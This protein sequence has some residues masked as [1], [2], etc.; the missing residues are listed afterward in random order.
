MV[1]KV[2]TETPLEGH[3]LSREEILKSK[4]IGI[5]V[6]FVPEWGGSVTVKGLSGRQRDQFEISLLEG[7]GKN[8]QVNLRNLRAKL[9]AMTI[10]NDKGNP[11][12]DDTDAQALG[13]KSASALQKVYVV[14]TR[15]SGLGEDDVEELT[16]ELGKDQ[17]V[18]SGSVLPLLSIS[19]P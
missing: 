14:A 9:V 18:D 12:F 11:I 15:L 7:K 13:E 3:F 16:E 19:Q 2:T 6:V 1:D 8:R 10:V 17:S 5:E 4:D